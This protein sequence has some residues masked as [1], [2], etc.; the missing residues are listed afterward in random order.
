MEPTI[1]TH[2]N[3]ADN[4]SDDCRQAV[5]NPAMLAAGPVNPGAQGDL[6]TRSVVGFV[7]EQLVDLR[8]GKAPCREGIRR[9]NGKFLSLTGGQGAIAVFGIGQRV[10]PVAGELES[11][12]VHRRSQHGL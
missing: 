9:Q 10:P 7:C 12:V 5:A 3:L 1:A 8:L 2:R 6:D 4:R 11:V